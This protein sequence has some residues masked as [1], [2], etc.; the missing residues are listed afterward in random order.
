MRHFST[1]NNFNKMASG[2]IPP[3]TVYEFKTIKVIGYGLRALEM[4]DAVA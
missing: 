2:K 3:S 1:L 4:A